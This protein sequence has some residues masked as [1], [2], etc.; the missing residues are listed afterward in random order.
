[1]DQVGKITKQKTSEPVKRATAFNAMNAVA[2][3]MGSRAFYDSTWGSARKASLHPRLYAATC[4]AG[5]ASNSLGRLKDV[6]G[7]EADAFH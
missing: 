1:M 4:F 2:H 5:S 7:G 3:F 6:S